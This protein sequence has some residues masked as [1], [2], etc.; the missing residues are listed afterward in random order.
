MDSRQSVRDEEPDDYGRAATPTGRFRR[1]MAHLEKSWAVETR[2]APFYPFVTWTP[3]GPRLGAS[4]LLKRNG[5]SE[6]D[7]LLALL[8]VAY[9]RDVPAGALKHLAWAQREFQRG[10]LRSRRCTSR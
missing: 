2:A 10:D 4:T 9:A 3:D 7:R 5:R 8:S 6:D 1:T